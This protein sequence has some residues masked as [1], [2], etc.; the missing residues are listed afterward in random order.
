MNYF[1]YGCVDEKSQAW[2]F[3]EENDPRI[4]DTMIKLSREEWQNLLSEQSNG[5]QIV[6][7]ENKVFATDEIGKYYLDVDNVWKKK[8]DDVFS[9][10][11]LE[12][13]KNTKIAENEQKRQVEY[14]NT[15]IGKLKTETPLGDLKTALPIYDKIATANN[16]LP[17]NSVR[18]Y[19]DGHI[20]GNPTLSLNEYNKI[21]LKVALEYI[22][23]DAYSTRLTAS[24]LNAK[25]IDEL[26]NISIDYENLPDVEMEF[27]G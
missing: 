27:K 21:S 5:K 6:C 9:A 23:I 16:G 19:N 18:L 25:S 8:A 10:E 17:A 22:K 14:I 2:G 20:T 24:I 1:Y 13:A 11:K 4:N 3:V 26:N 7:F 12:Q 15:P